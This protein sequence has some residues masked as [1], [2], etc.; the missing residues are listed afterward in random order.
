MKISFSAKVPKA[1][2]DLYVIAVGSGGFSKIKGAHAKIAKAI[3][4]ANPDFKG[5]AGEIV[6]GVVPGFKFMRLAVLGVGSDMS[7]LALEIA[8]G[9]LIGALRT[10]KN[11]FVDTS[12]V[13]G[14]KG[15]AVA[16]LASGAALRGYA[17]MTYRTKEKK[18]SLPVTLTLMGGNDAQRA[19]G[20][21]AK[22]VAAVH[23]ARDLVNEPS[24]VLYP[25]AF[26]KR[27]KKKL[28]PLGVK[29]SITDDKTLLKK[30]FGAMIAVGKAGEYKPRLVVM[31]YKGPRAPKGRP[32]ALIG[33]GITFDSGGYSIKPSDG[34]IEMKC[35]M[36]GAAA[37][38]GAM[39]TLASTRANVHVVAALAM[40]ENMISDE[41]FKP[42]DIIT[43]LS[44]QTIEITNTDAEGRLVLCDAMWHIQDTYK[45]RV[46]A[47]IATLTGGALVTFGQ[48]YAAVFSNDDSAWKAMESAAK[49]TGDKVWRLPLD[50]A[51]DKMMDSN[52]ADMKNA[53]ASRYAQ[54]ATGA[55]FLQRYVQKGVNWVHVD[56]AP[57]MVSPTDTALGPKGPTGYGV[58]LLAEWARSV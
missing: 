46:C 33:K 4:A 52:V 55:A 24:N 1:N 26:A 31:E 8:G 38:A 20:E 51:F 25:D 32:V 58:R 48:E 43:S 14:L 22:A 30:G 13:K 35:D 10:A 53:A 21:M 29:V 3:L 27:V 9:R 36:A 23:W 49:A 6:S 2:T 57:T 56:M 44:G 15:A 7:A 47:D 37:V 28:S 5:E 11:V 34:M 18:D 50:K 41:G 39:M 42:S 17:F 19:Y 45:P 16:A 40:A 54:S 12:E